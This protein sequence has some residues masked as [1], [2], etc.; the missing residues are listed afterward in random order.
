VS[1]N[2]ARPGQSIAITVPVSS[3][4]AG[5]GIL[6]IEVYDGA[7]TRVAQNAISEQRFN[8]GQVRT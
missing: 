7:G 4:T 8:A 2:T 1:P 6:D 5:S 3:A